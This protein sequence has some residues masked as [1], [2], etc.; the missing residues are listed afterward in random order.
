MDRFESTLS[1][2]LVTLIGHSVES[3]I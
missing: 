2:M 3:V 1:V